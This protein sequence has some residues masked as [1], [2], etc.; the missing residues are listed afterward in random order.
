MKRFLTLSVALL[1]LVSLTLVGCSSNSNND[2]PGQKDLQPKELLQQAFTKAEN[3]QSAKFEGSI[4]LNL[5]I[6]ASAFDDPSELMTLN[7]IN[8]AELTFRGTTQLDPMMT[9]LFLTAHLKGDLSMDLTV[10]ILM[11][12]DKVW[13]KIPNTPFFPLPAELIDKYLEIDFNELSQLAGEEIA[14]NTDFQEQYLELGAEIADI[15]FGAFDE[16]QYFTKLGKNDPDY[17]SDADVSQVLKFEL[18]NDNLRPFL[19]S[20][21]EVMPELLDKLAQFD[22]AGLTQAEIDELREELKSGKEEIE[23]SLD[24]LEQALDIKE[25]TIITGIDK[26]GYVTYMSA[27][28]DLGIDVEGEKGSIGFEVVTKQSDINAKN[29]KFELSEPKSNDV[30]K[31]EEL[32]SSFMMMN[33]F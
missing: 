27:N 16:D 28:V 11:T 29:Q 7:L 14:L 4:K 1:L 12:E 10:P 6:P 26:G 17:P 8:N 30:I 25:A 20:L 31:L 18:T 15:F 9:E 13:V 24:E 3:I 33:M 22:D 2:Q 23:S 19:E 21:I 5:D 32:L